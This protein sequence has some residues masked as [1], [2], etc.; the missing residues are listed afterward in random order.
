MNPT[1][2]ESEGE[3]SVTCS[4]LS[5]VPLICDTPERRQEAE[6]IAGRW[7]LPL[8]TGPDA[9][10]AL[11]LTEQRLELRETGPGAPG[12]VYVDFVG[13]AVGHRRRFG[14]GRG[15]ALARAAGLKRG[16]SPTVLDATAGLGR[17][18]FVLASL[19]CPVSLVERSPVLGALLED[20]LRR[21]AEDPETA[22]IAERM[23]LIPGESVA[24]MR[25]LADSEHPDVV[26]LDPMYP[27]RERRAQI[28]KEMRLLQSL[29]GHDP[30]AGELLPAALACA[31]LRVVVK[32]PDYAEPL[33]GRAPTLT[34]KTKRHRFDVYVVKAMG[35]G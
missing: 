21:A 29:V 20:G 25:A 13:G 32:R 35:S 6:A 8:E 16:H 1:A 12:P 18:A 30:D 31:R 27:P 28:K 24:V 9:P 3:N 11:H 34:H 5:P 7:H 19:G 4:P 10:L 17:D 2:P 15:Q 33:L 23:A 14:G 26:Y 22:P